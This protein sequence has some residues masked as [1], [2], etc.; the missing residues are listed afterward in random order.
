M[1]T[2]MAAGGAVLTFGRTTTGSLTLT[3]SYPGMH[4]ARYERDRDCGTSALIIAAWRDFGGG[5]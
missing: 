4:E 2:K 1:L 3:V 5:S